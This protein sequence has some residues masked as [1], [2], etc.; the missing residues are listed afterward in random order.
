MLNKELV[1]MRLDSEA[2]LLVIEVTLW[3]NIL[4]KL[5]QDLTFSL[6]RQLHADVTWDICTKH[7]TSEQ[8]TDS[9]DLQITKCD[10]RKLLHY[11]ELLCLCHECL[12][13]CIN[14]TIMNY[15]LS[16]QELK[17]III[18]KI[19]VLIVFFFF[20]FEFLYNSNS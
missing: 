20:S 6:I 7:E 16:C 5:R 14:C 4:L 18:K 2:H 8:N 15:K 3:L 11:T 13:V 1:I 10:F 19:L 12:F 17:Y 9:T